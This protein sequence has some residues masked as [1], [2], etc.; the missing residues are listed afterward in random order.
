MEGSRLPFTRIGLENLTSPVLRMQVCAMNGYS[1]VDT[2]YAWYQQQQQQQCKSP[3][4]NVLIA[5]NV[6]Q[7]DNDDADRTTAFLYPATPVDYCPGCVALCAAD[8]TTAPAISDTSRSASSS[9]S[10]SLYHRLCGRAAL[11]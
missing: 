8:A 2:E 11:L 10:V 6:D 7:D 3:Y 9:S 5:E 4:T 1:C